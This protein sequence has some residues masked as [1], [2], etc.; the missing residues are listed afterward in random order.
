MIGSDQLAAELGYLPVT[1]AQAAAYMADQ[2]MT[3]ADYHALFTSRRRTLLELAPD[4]MPDDY[5]RP[6][7]VTLSLS[8]GVADQLAPVGL[9]RPLLTLLALLDPNGIPFDFITTGIPFDFITTP[10][11]RDYLANCGTTRNGM[12]KVDVEHARSALASLYRLNLANTTQD[13]AWRVI[14]VHAL[15]LQ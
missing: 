10:A 15:V 6:V 7:A 2:D 12:E 5:T 11:V 1:L 3:C 8:V 9:A 4:S 14:R 13:D